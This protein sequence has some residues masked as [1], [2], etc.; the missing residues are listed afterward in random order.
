MHGS[1]QEA[2]DLVLEV[3]V[4]VFA[5]APEPGVG[6]LPRFSGRW[7]TVKVAV[8]FNHFIWIEDLIALVEKGIGAGAGSAA[9]VESITRNLGRIFS[10]HSAIS[11]FNIVVEN[12]AGGYSTFA[13]LESS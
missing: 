1:L 11:W 4:P 7:G 2:D 5:P 10:G 3:T 12:L 13:A 6:A 9:S 8:R